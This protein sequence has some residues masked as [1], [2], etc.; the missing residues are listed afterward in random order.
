MAKSAVWGRREKTAVKK[1]KGRT[2]GN[3][4]RGGKKKDAQKT[5]R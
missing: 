4:H 2:S 3:R 5:G 1:S